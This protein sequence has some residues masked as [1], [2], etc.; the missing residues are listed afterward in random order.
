MS[1]SSDEEII[2]VKK[3]P[4]FWAILK[5]AAGYMFLST[6]D[7]GHKEGDIQTDRE[8]EREREGER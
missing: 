5:T 1:S 6:S 3:A 2:I 4:G 7:A 8:S